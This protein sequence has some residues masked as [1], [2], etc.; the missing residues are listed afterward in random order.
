MISIED[1]WR[2][3]LGT[4]RERLGDASALRAGAALDELYGEGQGEGANSRLGGGGPAGFSTREWSAE[5]EHLFGKRVRDQ[6]LGRAA[7]RGRSDVLSELSAE[8]VTPSVELLQQLLSLKGAL[9]PDRLA[10]LRQLVGFVVDELVRVL[11]TQ[12]RPAL[13]GSVISRP[14]RRRGGPLD[15]R[16]TVARNL[17]S[18]R[19]RADG[20]PQ[21]VADRL[22]FK[23][24]ARRSLD[25]RIVLVV[26]VSG[27]MEASVV[28]SALMAAI[29]S[30]LPAVTV[31]FVAFS[32]NVIDL[33]DR[34][35][36]PLALLMEI[37]VGGGT[38]IAQALRY[39]R[40]LISN[41][42]RTLV[43]LVSDFEEGGPL[44]PL[45]AEVR[46]I[47]E[48]GARP[49]GLAAL[50]DRGAPRFARAIAEE[51]AAAGM[52]IAAVTPTELAAWIGEQLR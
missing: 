2:L 31:H 8:S 14:T 42:R 25:W 33:S 37:V 16:R 32:T 1:R 44:A 19:F 34:V 38:D 50:D 12:V 48:S 51:V 47:A 17:R 4:E 21:L 13:H 36:D 46:G 7:A 49:L 41:P 24:R 43:L 5:L 30:S 29:L 10:K 22:I 45:L 23:T 40:Q 27:S 20:T 39:A 18:V 28:Y 11:A 9:P 3:I 26:D 6:V 52:P 35:M 15:L